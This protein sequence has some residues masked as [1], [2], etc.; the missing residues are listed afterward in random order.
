MIVAASFDGH[1]IEREMLALFVHGE[2]VNWA[3]LDQGLVDVFV[4]GNLPWHPL[5]KQLGS[6]ATD[7]L[8]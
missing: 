3:Q 4:E 8:H 5:V 1:A 7:E 6:N 2:Q